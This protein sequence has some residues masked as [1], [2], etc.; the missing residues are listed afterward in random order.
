[1]RKEFAKPIEGV[2]PLQGSSVTRC[3]VFGVGR[4]TLKDYVPALVAS[5]R[6]VDLVAACDVEPAAEKRLVDELERLGSGA[7]PL[8]FTDHVALLDSVCPDL[9]IVV[10]PHHTHDDIVK[11]LFRRGVPVLKEKPFALSSARARELTE[12]VEEYDGHLRL[13]VQRRYHPLYLRARAALAEI[14]GLRHFDAVYQL[15]TDA[16]QAGWRASLDTSGGGAVIDMGY[17]I[18]DLLHWFFGMPSLVYASAAPKLVPTASYDIEETV[19]ANLSYSDGV[20]GTLRLSLCEASKEELIR[21]YGT[22]GYIRLTRDSFER[23]DRSNNLVER[24]AADHSWNSAAGV[25]A[26]TLDNLTDPE[27]TRREIA[28]G[29]RVTATIDALYRSIAQQTSVKPLHGEN[30]GECFGSGRRRG[31]AG[32]GSDDGVSVAEAAIGM[33]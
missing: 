20:T 9:A 14:G 28:D 17:H 29:V 16:Y 24:V 11:E 3:A 22:A 5:G 26:D 31:T 18:I 2:D 10:T 15:S 12:A 25:L 6:R 7:R 23:F 30:S 1:M 19:L 32:T 4:R 21:V 33:V 8:F 13:C 27:V